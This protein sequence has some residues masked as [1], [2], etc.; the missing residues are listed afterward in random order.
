MILVFVALFCIAAFIANAAGKHARRQKNQVPDFPITIIKNGGSV[1]FNGYDEARFKEETEKVLAR[2]VKEPAVINSSVAE[3]SRLAVAI[4]GTLSISRQDAAIRINST[5]NAR[6]VDRVASN[7]D[8][9]V[10][11]RRDTSKARAASAYG[12]TVISEEELLQYLKAGEFPKKTHRAI[13]YQSNNF[14]SEIEW[15]DTFDPPV[16]YAIEYADKEGEYTQRNISV[17]HLCGV[18]DGREYL[19]AYDNG[20]F[21]TFRRDHILSL[22]PAN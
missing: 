13:Q 6:F 9:L 20:V 12:T 1:T 15:R 18:R 10:A 11:A 3:H 16:T 4:T 17:V 22:N 8:Y 2:R 7:T 14:L 5:R 19:G 21:K